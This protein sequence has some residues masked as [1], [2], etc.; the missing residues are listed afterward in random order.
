LDNKKTPGAEMMLE[1]RTFG[2]LSI[3]KNG[4]TTMT[5]GS[6]K[7][8]ALL[9]Y[10][11]V[12][13][14]QHRRNVLAAQ[15]WPESSEKNTQV[16]LR[17]ALSTLNR[18]LGDYLVI[19]REDLGINPEAEIYVD[20]DDL[21][22]KL[23]SERVQEALEIYRGDFLQGFYISD[24]AEFED[25]RRWKLER[26]RNQLIT[27]LHSAISRAINARE[28][29]KGQT[30]VDRLLQIDPID[31]LAYQQSMLLLARS[32]Q[33]TA[34]LLQYEKC[35]RLLQEELDIQPSEETQLLY[36]QILKGEPLD[37]IQSLVVRHN[38][39][40][41]QTSFVGRQ[42]E[43]T[44][45]KDLLDNPDCRLL[46]LIGPGGFGKTRLALQA[47]SR[48]LR[49]FSDGI[50]F[51]SLEPSTSPDSLLPAIA[52]ALQFNID[53]LASQLEPEDQLVDYVRNRSVLLVLDSAEYLKGGTELL[54]II[55]EASRNV[56][57]L[58]TSR[59]KLGLRGEW[60]L[61]VDGLPVIQNIANTSSDD[62]SA[63]K[64]FEERVS[65]ANTI[66]QLSDADYPHAARICE[67]LEG[68]PLGIELAAAW[69]P[70]ISVKE[71]SEEM[72]K[73]LDFLRTSKEDVSEKH[74]SLRAA[75]ES[76]WSLL[77]E[78][79]KETF[80]KLSVFSG[81]FDR[82]AAL[83]V[84]E[85]DLFNLSNLMDKSLLKRNEIGRFHMHSALHQYAL[86]RLKD[87]GDLFTQ[88]FDRHCR[89]YI[90]FLSRREGDLFS[91]KMITARDE[92]QQEM[93]NIQSAVNW[94]ITRWDE[95]TARNILTKL[96]S[97]YA[98]DG[99][100]EGKNTFKAIAA[101]R[102]YWLENKNTPDAAMDPVYLSARIHQAFLLSNLGQTDESEAISK[103]CCEPLR[104][105]GLKAELSECLHNLGLN[106]SFRGEYQRARELLE[107]AVS[108]GGEVE[109]TLWPTYLLW[110]GHVYFLLGEY[111]H[112]MQSFRQCYDIYERM[113]SQWG[114]A[115]AL[116]KMGLAADGLGEY[117]HALE[118]HHEALVRSRAAGDPAA[119]AYSLSR[120]SMSAY[121]LEDYVQAVEFGREGLEIFEEL[122]HRWGICTSFCRLGFA[123]IGL[124]DLATARTDFL[125][126][127]E[128]SRDYHMVPLSL[129]A[130]LG[131]ACIQAQCGEERKAAG[132]FRY[133]QSH[134]QTPSIYIQNAV[135]WIEKEIPESQQAG[136][137]LSTGYLSASLDEMIDGILKAD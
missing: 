47:A 124:G 130:L 127:L 37:A 100:H 13:G 4:G 97:Y 32:G 109:H 98:V 131:T 91:Q 108:I 11:A 78:G 58:V 112:G 66:N 86:E 101:S 57:M 80:C 82:Q 22:E 36:Q 104:K 118:Y 18:A 45:I 23:A 95:E 87:K 65:Q 52:N 74:R 21:S 28:W 116:S 125:Q 44:R 38:L 42:A 8:E 3:R 46:T 29:K 129:Y 20:S 106:A 49:S 51:V 25:W 136:M 71:I 54:S 94:C 61:P 9:V 60:I 119:I 90:D 50:F 77:S 111:Q 81:E 73:N 70:I 53:T 16:S 79:Q 126:A 39:P 15:L 85:A 102:K 19:S 10:L 89:Y 75:F 67:M 117:S 59:Q 120:M 34:G 56:K 105:Y 48:S 64:L 62:S 135:R 2:G 93:R 96:Q 17:V 76:S 24:S 99:W 31:E 14:G 1:I 26:L 43:L 27:A 103:E 134:P 55:L 30:F 123:Y 132:L 72:Q 7:A 69:T 35:C 114:T 41:P 12:E 6:H 5:L 115:F 122:G 84:A 40:V 63:M 68:M 88:T 137:N 113:G 128:Q 110:L 33:R 92:I 121:F 83:Q 133:V 107:E